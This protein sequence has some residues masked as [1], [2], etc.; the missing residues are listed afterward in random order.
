M[1][2]RLK[3]NLAMELAREWIEKRISF[4][5]SNYPFG[6]KP[7]T[8]DELCIGIDYEPKIVKERNEVYYKVV[9]YWRRRGIHYWDELENRG[10]IT[11]TNLDKWNQFLWHYN[12]TWNAYIFLYD[13]KNGYYCQPGFA[14]KERIDHQRILRQ[15]DGAISVLSEMGRYGERLLYTGSQTDIPKLGKSMD[16]LRRKCLMP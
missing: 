4:K 12:G 10:I 9:E 14:E 2:F 11:G 13:R 7:F 5:I 8:L 16:A 6:I 1:A 3:G 15:I